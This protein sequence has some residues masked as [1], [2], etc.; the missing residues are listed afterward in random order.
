MND[1]IDTVK[2]REE[3]EVV[4]VEHEF[5]MDN[6]KEVEH[7][8]VDRG[9]KLSCEGATHPHHSHFKIRAIKK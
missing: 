9:L 2:Y 1:E 3:D 4:E 6:P 8:W 5:D 7:V